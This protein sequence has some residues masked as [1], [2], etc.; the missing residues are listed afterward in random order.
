MLDKLKPPKLEIEDLC[1]PESDPIYSNAVRC[2]Q[3]YWK[4]AASMTKGQRQKYLWYLQKAHI[5]HFAAKPFECHGGTIT[6]HNLYQR[7]RDD[8]GNFIRLSWPAYLL[9]SSLYGDA[10]K[11]YKEAIAKKYG[12]SDIEDHTTIYRHFYPAP[13]CAEKS[14]MGPATV[15][16]PKNT[17]EGESPRDPTP[18]DTQRSVKS[19]D[20]D[21]AAKETCL[22]K[23]EDETHV[24][25]R[26][27][28]S[29]TSETASSRGPRNIDNVIDDLAIPTNKRSCSAT[30][31]P[32]KR[33]K[34]SDDEILSHINQQT[35][36]IRKIIQESQLDQ[37]SK[38]LQVH[39]EMENGVKALN[40]MQKDLRQFMAAVALALKDI[41]EHL[42]E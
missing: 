34:L 19:E 30:Q 9:L 29:V 24:E 6:A 14:D 18:S 8:A 27:P 36:T 16:S 33:T 7:A 37:R 3:T 42:N 13:T 35:E 17:F 38:L 23:D 5:K 22:S 39:H 4:Q 32:P 25:S 15:Q 28:S 2:V 26:N 21:L 10:P 11:R 20:E 40:G 12:T 41:R 1:I 31:S